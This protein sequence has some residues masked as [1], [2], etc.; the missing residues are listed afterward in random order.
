MLDMTFPPFFIR[1]AR[2]GV[3]SCLF[4]LLRPGKAATAMLPLFRKS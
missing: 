2:T 1:A 3:L 4:F